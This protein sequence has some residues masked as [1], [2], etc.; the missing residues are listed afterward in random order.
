MSRSL[1]KVTRDDLEKLASL[2]RRHREG[3]FRHD[4]PTGKSKSRFLTWAA[5]LI[6][7]GAHPKEI[8]ERLGHPTIRITFD[9]HGHLFPSLDERLQDGLDAAFESPRSSTD[10]TRGSSSKGE[11]HS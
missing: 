10:P 11:Q 9:P 7:Q 2:S 4:K 6:A 8:Q 3:W 1:E 5:L